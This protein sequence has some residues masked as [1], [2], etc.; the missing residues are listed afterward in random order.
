MSSYSRQ[1]I[2]TGN[3][4]TSLSDIKIRY[5]LKITKLLIPIDAL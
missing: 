5:S 3:F 4:S 1:G 2:S